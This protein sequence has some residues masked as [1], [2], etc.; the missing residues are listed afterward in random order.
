MVYRSHGSDVSFRMHKKSP[1]YAVSRPVWVIIFG[2]L[3]VPSVL[4]NARGCDVATVTSIFSVSVSLVL[5][6]ILWRMKNTG[7][8]LSVEHGQLHAWYRIPSTN[9]RDKAKH[10]WFVE[11]R[12][13]T[14][15][16]GISSVTVEGKYSPYRALIIRD[17]DEASIRIPE[18]LLGRKFDDALRALRANLPQ[19][20][21]R[22]A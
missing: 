12:M 17:D 5:A 3:L 18:D 9:L 21:P 14:P 13:M 7:C 22:D 10:G 6:V 1:L 19:S 4:V 2:A 8:F 16:S 15:V 20:D 11:S